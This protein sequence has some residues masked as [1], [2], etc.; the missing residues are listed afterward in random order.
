MGDAMSEKKLYNFDIRQVDNG[1]VL[2][3]AWTT[4]SD[5]ELSN[6][7]SA[8]VQRVYTNFNK[9]MKDIKDTVKVE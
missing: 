6:I 8:G 5:D 3:M 4:P 7:F 2:N 9:M 1:W